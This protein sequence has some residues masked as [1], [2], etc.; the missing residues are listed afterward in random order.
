MMANFL[1]TILHVDMNAF[2]AYIEQRD[3]LELRGVMAGRLLLQSIGY[4][5]ARNSV[6]PIKKREPVLIVRGEPSKGT[7]FFVFFF[8]AFPKCF[9][10]CLLPSFTSVAAI[11]IGGSFWRGVKRLQDAGG[12]CLSG[13]RPYCALGSRTLRRP[14]MRDASR[15]RREH[16]RTALAPSW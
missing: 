13:Q 4:P 14:V 6:I 5:L 7:V 9:L 2:Y 12:A 16:C 15:L 8:C 11:Q 1:M 3:R 10:R